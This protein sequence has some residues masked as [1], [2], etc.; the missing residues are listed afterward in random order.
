MKEKMSE[1]DFPMDDEIFLSEFFSDDNIPTSTSSQLS[2][3]KS[4]STSSIS[5]IELECITNNEW[6][7]VSMNEIYKGLGTYDGQEFPPIKPSANHKV[8]IEWPLSPMSV[9][10]PYPHILIEDWRQNYV[11]MPY[12]TC[13]IYSIEQL[14]DNH[15][16]RYRWEVIKESLLQS[17]MSS[18]Q[19]EKAIL[20]YNHPYAY[21]WSFSALHHFFLETLEEEEVT[22]FFKTLFPKMV[23]LAL[24]LPKLVTGPIPLL[25]SHSNKTISLS[26]QQVSCLLANAFFCTFPGRNS[27]SPMFEY[28]NYPHINFNRLF[29][30]IRKDKPNRRESVMEKFK[31]IFHYFK[32]VTSQIPEGVITIQRRYIPRYECPKWDKIEKKLLPLHITSSG[33]IDNNGAGLLQV[34]FANRYVGGGVLTMG[35]VQEEIRFVICPELMVTMLVTEALDDTEALV[36]SGVERY[37]KYEGY[38]NSFKWTGDFVD[39]TP[40]D[41]SGRRK[42]TIV[43]IDALRFIQTS[44]QF[45]LNKII[46]E[47]NKAYVGFVGYDL[48]K[49]NLPGVATG[50]WGCGAFRGNPKLKVLLQ[51]MA[52][53]VA[54]RAMVYFTFGDPTLRDEIAAMHS[55]LVKQNI[56]IA[57]LFSLLSQYGESRTRHQDFYDYLY[58]KTRTESTSA[59]T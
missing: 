26:Q 29:A 46:R 50:N 13:R 24:Q 49:D 4:S 23:D 32:R 17:I 35:C 27:S 53:S 16:R 12:S 39:E 11:H 30:A 51:L 14:G 3:N 25:E 7:G 40:R 1:I 9:P 41:S 21:K 37:S 56:S 42:T 45:N 34:D 38:S 55:H 6:K 10:T 59:L 8:L 20:S 47:L 18:H 52:A 54:G 48:Y 5:V 43:A 36:V 28:S 44:L 57:H 31:C 2:S 19:L 33:T 15:R 22:A 58:S